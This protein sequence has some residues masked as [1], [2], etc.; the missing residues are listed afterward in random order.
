M[1][2]RTIVEILF[3]LALFIMGACVGIIL[4]SACIVGKWSDNDEN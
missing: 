2:S 1:D 3:G 4:Y